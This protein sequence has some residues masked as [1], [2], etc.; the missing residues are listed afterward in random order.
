M[1]SAILIGDG[2]L[3]MGQH[4]GPAS[5]AAKLAWSASGRPQVDHR[6]HS[7]VLRIPSGSHIAPA[8]SG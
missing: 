1:S 7:T 4:S 5:R 3:A 6:P 8:A 2:H